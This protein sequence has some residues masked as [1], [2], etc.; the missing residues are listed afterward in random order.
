MIDSSYDE[1]YD[2]LDTPSAS[3]TDRID[4]P[5]TL[6][7]YVT[8]MNWEP[9]QRESGKTNRKRNYFILAIC[10]TQDYRRTD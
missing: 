5:R 7:D 1:N 4:D 8:F 2:S 9:D 3:Y 6:D 10:I